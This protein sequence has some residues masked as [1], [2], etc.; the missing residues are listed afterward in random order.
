MGNGAREH[1][2][3]R[4]ETGSTRKL[5]E[6]LTEGSVVAGTRRGG[7]TVAG[8]LGGPRKKKASGVV[9]RGVRRGAAQWRGRGGRGGASG[10]LEGTR[11]RRWPPWCSS[12]AAG[13]FGPRCGGEGESRGRVREVGRIGTTPGHSPTRPEARRQA[14][15][16]VAPRARVRCPAS[17]YWQRLGM[18]G[19][20]P[21]GLGHHR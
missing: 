9:L 18:T 1:N 4:E 19:T 10:L 17:A 2:R 20:R 13:A 12:S 8:D 5:T 21:G 6:R 3:E 11:G 16:G 15:G 14:G 7:H